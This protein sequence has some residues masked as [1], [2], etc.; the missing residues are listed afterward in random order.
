MIKKHREKEV[1]SKKETAEFLGISVATLT[2][3]MKRQK[4]P[5][6]KVE[7]R[8]FFLKEEILEWIKS[9]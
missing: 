9:H 2:N 6:H 5:Y 7:R 1:L 8:V 4:I 3:W